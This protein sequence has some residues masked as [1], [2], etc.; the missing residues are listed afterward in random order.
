MSGITCVV[1][2]H[3]RMNG[4]VRL[5]IYLVEDTRR[6]RESFE[7]DRWRSRRHKSADPRYLGPQD[8]PLMGYFA[9]R[10][11]C[12]RSGR[13]SFPSCKTAVTSTCAGWMSSLSSISITLITITT[14]TTSGVS[15][16][17]SAS[18]YGSRTFTNHLRYQTG[19]IRY[20]CC[21]PRRNT[22]SLP[23]PLDQL[24]KQDLS[25]NLSQQHTFLLEE[26]LVMHIHSVQTR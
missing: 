1:V 25:R 22:S 11:S 7:S 9:P 18:R 5:L 8:W 10:Q 13:Q 12:M 14:I 17:C 3:E 2:N 16:G 23:H 26:L 24:G 15:P 4:F 19:T 21:S 20:S 6:N